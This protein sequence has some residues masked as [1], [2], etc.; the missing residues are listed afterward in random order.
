MEYRKGGPGLA[1]ADSRHVLYS[2]QR[3]DSSG[4]ACVG[5]L[6]VLCTQFASKDCSA[7][8]PV[9]EHARVRLVGLGPTE[10]GSKSGA[11]EQA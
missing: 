1:L 3:M 9:Q 2:R 8:S 11:A 7:P 10:K 6:G 5:I 4:F